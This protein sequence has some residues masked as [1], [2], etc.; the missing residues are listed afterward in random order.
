MQLLWTAENVDRKDVIAAIRG[1]VLI[2]GLVHVADFHPPVA[3]V[4]PFHAKAHEDAVLVKAATLPEVGVVESNKQ[5]VPDDKSAFRTRAKIL[6]K[7][8]ELSETQPGVVGRFEEALLEPSSQGDLEWIKLSRPSPLLPNAV[9]VNVLAQDRRRANPPIAGPQSR[10][11][12]NIESDAWSNDALAKTVVVIKQSVVA[13]K[14]PAQSAVGISRRNF[15]LGKERVPLP[16]I[17]HGLG[18]SGHAERAQR[19][20]NGE[21]M[22]T[23]AHDEPPRT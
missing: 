23:F 15:S 2:D 18:G 16:D 6:L 20:E 13:I 22:T 11:L 14:P 21:K 12:A 7:P 5:F 4:V 19:D 10:V 3:I 17:V 1:P 9:F 8:R